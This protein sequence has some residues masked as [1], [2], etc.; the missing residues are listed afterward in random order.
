MDM[1]EFE[2]RAARERQIAISKQIAAL[3]AESRRLD[4]RIAALDKSAARDELPCW[5][6]GQPQAINIRHRLGASYNPKYEEATSIGGLPRDCCRL[7]TVQH[8]STVVS[9]A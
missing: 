3:E 6:C 1:N 5:E 7:T 4:V 8:R 9:Q 2:L